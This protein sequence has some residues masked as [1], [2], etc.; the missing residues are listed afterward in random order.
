[1]CQIYIQYE[2]FG[3]YQTLTQ[4]ILSTVL[5]LSCCR[6]C[7]ISLSLFFSRPY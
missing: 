4:C 3:S 5:L 7:Y 2:S 6:L 1:M